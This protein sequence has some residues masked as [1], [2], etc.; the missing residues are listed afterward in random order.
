MNKKLCVV[1]GGRWGQNHIRTLYEMGNLGGIVESS[2]E[3]LK[4]LLI[5][6]PVKGFSN[7]DRAMSDSLMDLL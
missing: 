3:R 6:Y 4:E 7:I 5:K 1:G 2:K